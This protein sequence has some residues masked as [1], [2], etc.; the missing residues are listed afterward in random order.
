MTQDPLET[1]RTGL[2]TAL[3]TFEARPINHTRLIELTCESTSPDVAAQFLNAMAQE[4]VE[5][6]SHSAYHHRAQDQRVSW[7]AA[8]IEETKARVQ[9]AEE[10]LRA[11]VSATG[12]VFAGPDAT[13]DDTRLSQL[14]GELAK[15]QSERI[16]RQT[17]YELTVKNPPESLGEVLDD[18][19]LRGYQA[20]L[21][22]LKK[23][24][25][26]LD[27]TYTA[28][29]K[30][31]Q[32]IEAEIATVQKAYDA[33]VAAPSKASKAITK[34][35]EARRNDWWGPTTHSRAG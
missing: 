20:Q 28:K 21:Q 1:T 4:F 15:D 13:L 27:L 35:R 12:N 10:K 5:D 32:K 25:A 6:N 23:D 16:A 9:D 26:V 18:G 17:R 14:K 22:G 29:D 30:K 31:V 24:L 19:V 7:P 3:K 33:E 8:Q 11:F 34:L 2:A